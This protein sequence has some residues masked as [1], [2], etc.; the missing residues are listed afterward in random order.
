MLASYVANATC[1]SLLLSQWSR[2]CGLNM[3]HCIV[4]LSAWNSVGWMYSLTV[5]WECGSTYHWTELFLICGPWNICY[6]CSAHFWPSPSIFP[7]N[8]TLTFFNT[9]SVNLAYICLLPLHVQT[10]SEISCPMTGETAVTQWRSEAG[11]WGSR[12]RLDP[13]VSTRFVR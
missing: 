7:W 9:L 3:G 12:G 10:M 11:R 1:H 2:I 4:G 8:L 13:S 6:T 5:T